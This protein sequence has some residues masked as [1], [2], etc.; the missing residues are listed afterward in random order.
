MELK[1]ACTRPAEELGNG[2][3][4]DLG[5]NGDL[6]SLYWRQNGP[7]DPDTTPCTVS[8]GK[9]ILPN[10]LRSILPTVLPQAAAVRLM[11]M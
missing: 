7:W 9:A 4:M 6:S 8:F 3:H 5:V 1:E 11:S 10:E 2:A